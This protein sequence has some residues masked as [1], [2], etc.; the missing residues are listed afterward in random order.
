MKEKI[1]LN[2]FIISNNSPLVLFGG[3]NVLEDS[4]FNIEVAQEYKN[5]CEN[6]KI[7][8]VFKAS[9]DKANRSSIK[10][11]RGPGIEKGIEM[12]SEIK[13]MCNIPILTDV[14]TPDEAKIASVICD[15]IQLPAFLSRQTDLIKAMADTGSIINIKKAQ[16]LSPTQMKNIVNKFHE[17]GNEKI[18][19]CERGTNFGY[20]N[21]IVDM[22]GF[23]VIKE[24]CNNIP[25]IFDV[26]HA[27]QCRGHGSEASS[28][29]RS[30]VLDLAKSGI[31]QKL[32]GIF[33]ESHP[34][35]QNALCDGPSALPLEQ[36]QDFLI[37]I[38]EID[39]IVKKQKKIIIN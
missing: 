25:V 4:K 19:I 10:S 11:P 8:L 39:D 7:P 20:D 26:T 15:I 38:K 6:L 35:P 5:I 13:N 34:N 33:L 2:N 23:G 16:F 9:Y 31:A 28:G 37:Q 30:Q 14:H 24:H 18:I 3:I 22:L 32:A 12:L 27:L 1:I 17:C 29:R 21:L 36:L